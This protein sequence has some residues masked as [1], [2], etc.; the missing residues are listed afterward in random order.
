MSRALVLQIVAGLTI[1]L[2]GYLLFDHFSSESEESS[3][4]PGLGSL[5]MAIALLVV[6][7]S[8]EMRGS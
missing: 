6:A 8:N 4:L 5:I 3:M 2:G 1:L 7:S